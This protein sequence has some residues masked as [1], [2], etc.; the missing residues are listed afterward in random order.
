LAGLILG[1]HL[2]EVVVSLV[3]EQLEAALQGTKVGADGGS[4]DMQK[5]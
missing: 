2:D 3:A 1:F 5:V 4:P